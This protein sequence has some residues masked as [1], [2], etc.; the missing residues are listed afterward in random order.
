MPEPVKRYESDITLA[1]PPLVRC[2]PS[3]FPESAQPLPAKPELPHGQAVP[4]PSPGQKSV[5]GAALP[6]RTWKPFRLPTPETVVTVIEN[7]PP[8]GTLLKW[9]TAYVVPST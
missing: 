1:T 5:V 7:P 3:G 4:V 9:C 2:A 8:I 6:S